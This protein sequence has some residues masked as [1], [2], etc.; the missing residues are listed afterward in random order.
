MN[1]REV[2]LDRLAAGRDELAAAVE[3]MTDAQA[4]APPAGGG[5]SALQ[6]VEHVATVETRL[7]RRMQADSTVM[8]AEMSRERE[9]VLYE[10]IAARGRKVEAPE[11]VHP[12]GRYAD[13]R[14]ALAGFLTARERCMRWV[15]A[16][17]WDLRC[18]S[19]EHPAFGAVST[20][21]MVLIVAAHAARHARQIVEGR[22]AA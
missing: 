14:E 17:E 9:P 20:H 6:C 7:L 5:W 11:A 15:G 2:L 8:E 4:A 21:E 22:S 16:C 3:G 18:R 10:M 13:L 19:V 1:D 12:T